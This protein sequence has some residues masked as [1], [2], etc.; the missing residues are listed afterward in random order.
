M[1]D[2]PDWYQFNNPEKIDTPALLIYPE[3]VM[4]NINR[5]KKMVS[6]PSLLRPHVKTNKSV[7]VS[8]LMMDA[9]ITKFKC[10][11]IAEAEMLGRAGAPDVLLAYQPTQT[12]LKRFVQLILTYPK[13]T[14]SCTVDNETTADMISVTATANNFGYT[15]LYRFECRYEPYRHHP[16]KSFKTILLPNHPTGD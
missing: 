16:R 12:K 6:S 15:G 1:K 3:R 7:K 9:G 8:R 14:Y 11:T 13:T 10:A 2:Q 4:S 5:L